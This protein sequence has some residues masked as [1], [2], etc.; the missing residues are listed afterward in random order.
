MRLPNSQDAAAGYGQSGGEAVLAWRDI[1]A[2][3]H[4]QGIRLVAP[5]LQPDDAAL[6][7]LFV[8]RHLRD[9]LTVH[10]S[11]AVDLHNLTTR[12]VNDAGLTV[13]LFLAG[14]AN[15]SLAGRRQTVGASRDAG[16]RTVPML[17]LC[18]LAEPE[19]FERCAIRGE[20]LRKV[21]I[22]VSPDWLENVG[23]PDRRHALPT[24]MESC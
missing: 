6:R 10:M 19:I 9:G 14:R 18:S 22:R 1:A 15:I 13:T 7:G 21:S 11:D 8:R 2:L 17:T 23:W 24:I 12:V 20:H 5:D 4:D 3:V 16:G